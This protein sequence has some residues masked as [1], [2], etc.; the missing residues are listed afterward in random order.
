M[1]SLLSISIGVVVLYALYRLLGAL[2]LP[3][4]AQKRMERYKADFFKQNP[5]ISEKAYHD[6]QREDEDRTL[7][8][9]K[10]KRYLSR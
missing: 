3:R 6:R 2:L 5:H 9:E 4:I 1:N 7:I 10:R 8:I